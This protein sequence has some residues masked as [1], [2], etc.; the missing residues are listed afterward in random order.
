MDNKDN[1]QATL[2]PQDQLSDMIWGFTK[3]QLIYVAA[4]LD[5]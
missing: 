3:V 4:K 2:S 5:V 1:L